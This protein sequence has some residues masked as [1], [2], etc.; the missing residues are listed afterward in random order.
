M[1]R[2][3][4]TRSPRTFCSAFLSPHLIAK[5]MKNQFLR[6]LLHLLFI[7][8]F[9]GGMLLPHVLQARQAVGF[10]SVDVR[11]PS[12]GLNWLE[13][14]I[15]EELSLQLQL[16]DRFSVI[17][18]D[19]MRRWNQRLRNAGMLASSSSDLQNSEIAQLKP[20]RLLQI[21]LQKVLNQLSVTWDISS[22]GESKSTL[23]IQNTHS[24]VSPDKLIA[25][26]LRDLEGGDAFF[27]KLTHFPQGYSWE[28]IKR[29]YQLRLKQV[30]AP[31]TSAWKVHKDELELLLFSYPSLVSSIR[32]YR[33][34]LLII[35]SSVL[36][37][38]H[39]PAL[40]SAETEILAAMKQHPGSSQHHT[41]LS[42]V[43]YLR[44]EPLFAKQQANIANQ[45]NPGNGV[46]LILYGL[47]V[48]KTPQ[49]GTAYVS[50]GLKLYPF[51]GDPSPDGR[52]PYHVLVKVLE[53]WLMSAVSGKTPS[54]EQLM[55]SGQEDYN[56]RRWK[57]ALQ[58]FED[59]SALQPSLPEPHL[60][61]AKLRLAQQDVESALVLLTK[62]RKRFP[63]HPDINLYLGYAHE[64]LKHHQKAETLYR[65]VLHLKPEH[66][67]SLLRLGA[68]L[69]K[70]GK[71]REARSFLESLTRKYP[72]YTVG[73]WNLGI[74]YY[75]LGEM[76]LAES[77]WEESLRI[78]PDNSQIR[79][80]LAQFREEFS[81][82]PVSQ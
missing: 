14:F 52:Q 42:L 41:L 39:V 49:A 67:K 17:A 20:N 9:F 50:R 78:D 5:E 1:T 76:E 27:S 68:V 65:Y 75:Q 37:P 11:Y 71:R 33:A 80:R 81:Y 72:M 7:G 2:T 69:I 4:L 8:L 12:K 44:R 82:A 48:G 36:L 64:K 58:A 13:L 62:L 54:F 60:F 34:V 6:N 70:L 32:F 18:P 63:K 45:I 77:A 51:V 79:L 26:L 57:E 35:E 25:S 61:L 31:D 53:P 66:H 15:Q 55:I 3:A 29:F 73:W 47:T 30:P 40:N 43:H 28:G 56:A 16:A 46:S 24:W 59:A 10:L 21:S 23:K 22:F 19:N 74:V 38:A